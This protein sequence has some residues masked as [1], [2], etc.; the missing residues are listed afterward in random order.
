MNRNRHRILVTL[1]CATSLVAGI[2]LKVAPAAERTPPR[3]DVVALGENDVKQLIILLDQDKNG[4][5][6]EAEFMSFMKVEFTRLDTNHN[7]E[8]DVK[9]LKKSQLKPSST[10]LSGGK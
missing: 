1:G 3:R 6:S 2:F 7:G 5:V 8:L 10:F 9:E 4:T